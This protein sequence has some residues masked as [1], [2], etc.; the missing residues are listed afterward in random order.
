M[1]AQST[2]WSGFYFGDFVTLSDWM[3]PLTTQ[4][5]PLLG[6]ICELDRKFAR[7]REG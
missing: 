4:L 1:E 3:C 7:I 5:A 2:L 6:W